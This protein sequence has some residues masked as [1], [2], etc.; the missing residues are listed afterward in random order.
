MKIMLNE[1]EKKELKGRLLG[2]VSRK[3]ILSMI[4]LVLSTIMVIN[5]ELEAKYWLGIIASDVLGYNFSNSYSK[6]YKK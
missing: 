1:E 4:I 2:F 5:G 6:K 3:F